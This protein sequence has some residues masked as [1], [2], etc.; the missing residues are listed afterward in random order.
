M[1]AWL[2]PAV[3]VLKT[4]TLN[5]SCSSNITQ[6][7]LFSREILVYEFRSLEF[8]Q[9]INKSKWFARGQNSLPEQYLSEIFKAARE[10]LSIPVRLVAH[11]RERVMQPVRSGGALSGYTIPCILIVLRIAPVVVQPPVFMMSSRTWCWPHHQSAQ[12]RMMQI[13]QH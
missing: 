1:F 6:F 12:H 9:S 10:S 4:F 3:I 11:K 5:S 7:T 2:F 13:S 8:V